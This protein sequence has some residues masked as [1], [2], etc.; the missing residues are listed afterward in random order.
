MDINK[1]EN[2]ME[3]FGNPFDTKNRKPMFS[4]LGFS[5]LSVLD[6]WMGFASG[7]FGKDVR[8][9]WNEC[10]GGP[11]TI[12]EDILK[13]TFEFMGQDFTNIM[14]VISNLAL[15][16]KIATLIAQIFTELPNSVQACSGV[17]TEAADTTQ[18][19]IKHL[20]PASL[21]TN[22]VANLLTHL[23]PIIGDVWNLMIAIFSMKFYEIGRLTGALFIMIVN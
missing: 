8:E 3:S 22:V 12:I 10:L 17:Y 2:S 1:I 23:L 15:L 6:Y 19:V 7:V 5:E 21:L 16:T 9:E 13:I 4:V 20:N 18:F 11:L 14:G